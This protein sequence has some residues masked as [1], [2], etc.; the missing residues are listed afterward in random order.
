V[1]I[2]TKLKR[3]WCDL[4]HL[5]IKITR[6]PEGRINWQC[7]KCGLWGDH[8]PLSKES[9]TIDAEIRKARKAREVKPF[10]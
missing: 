6:D 4:T 10:A 2:K 9:L 8:I 7:S 3:W 1:T 5:T